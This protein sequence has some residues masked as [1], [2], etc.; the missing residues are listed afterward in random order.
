V[1]KPVVPWTQELTV[2]RAILA[3][4]YYAQAMPASIVLK[5]YGQEIKIDPKRLLNGED[6]ALQPGDVLEIRQ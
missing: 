2:A 5:R 1:K 4:E 3:S 6:F